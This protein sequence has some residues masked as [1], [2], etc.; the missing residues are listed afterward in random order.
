MKKHH[1][2]A[3]QNIISNP[4]FNQHMIGGAGT[5]PH[6]QDDIGNE[7]K[8]KKVSNVGSKEADGDC[9]PWLTL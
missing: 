1:F 8:K 9:H 2:K 6:E 7:K 3:L 4:T 5:D